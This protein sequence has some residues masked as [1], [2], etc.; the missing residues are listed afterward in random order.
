MFTVIYSQSCKLL[1]QSQRGRLIC[2]RSESKSYFEGKIAQEYLAS[3]NQAI[4]EING[5]KFDEYPRISRFP[6]KLARV[7][8]YYAMIDTIFHVYNLL[9]YCILFVLATDW[10]PD[11]WR[12]KTDCYI[13][14]RYSMA[15][16]MKYTQHVIVFIFTAFHLLWRFHFLVRKPEIRLDGIEFLLC[17]P[18]EVFTTETMSLQHKVNIND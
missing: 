6:A 8:Q 7:H 12:G 3:E 4:C 9:K 18:D 16:Q 11:S 17:R 15:V 13:F 2:A 1:V 5:N 14:G 10:L